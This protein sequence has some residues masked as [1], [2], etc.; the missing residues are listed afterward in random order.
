MLEEYII[1]PDS[2]ILL[3]AFVQTPPHA[4][5]LTAAPGIGTTTISHALAAQL[6][7]TAVAKLS[8]SP[9]ARLIAPVKGSIAIETV[10]ELRE[11]LR[12]SVP[13]S[14]AVKRVIVIDNA[15]TMSGEA[16]NALLKILEEP[17]VGTI[18]L[19][20]ST[21]PDHLLSTVRSRLQTLTLAT[22]PKQAVLD[23][24]TTRSF[25]LNDV[26]RAYLMS[27]GSIAELI[28]VLDTSSE[29]LSAFGTVKQVLGESTF[30]RLLHVDSLAKD[31]VAAVAFVTALL[32]LASMSLERV[33]THNPAAITNW[34]KILQAANTAHEALL[35]NGSA[36]LVLTDL[37]LA[38]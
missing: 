27:N 8:N 21:V 12:L 1:H 7:H 11:F 23:F 37:M 26:E 6:L 24:F 35:R 4:T 2:R 15:D 13:G 14:A 33:A 29:Q 18:L 28:K 3:E 34:H 22:P 9:Y 19:L 36:K 10:R 31:K 17:P 20:T 25:V 16:Q 30:E 5:L 32:Q 38:L